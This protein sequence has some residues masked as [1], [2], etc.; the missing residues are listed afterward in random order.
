MIGFGGVL[1][2]WS[3]EVFS[4]CGLVV[5]IALFETLSVGGGDV[6]DVSVPSQRLFPVP[7]A[8]GNGPR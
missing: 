7:G 1:I 6:I 2:F 5:E 8:G 3:C 4:F